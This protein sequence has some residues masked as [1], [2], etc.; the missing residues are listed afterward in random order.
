VGAQIAARLIGNW[1]ICLG[2]RNL[3]GEAG[4]FARGFFD[5]VG[6]CYYFR[7]MPVIFSLMI[8]VKYT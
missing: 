6:I 5:L 8:V 7:R 2:R 4:L 3:V 1:S